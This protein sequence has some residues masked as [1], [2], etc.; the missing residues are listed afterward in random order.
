M[1]RKEIVIGLVGNPNCG[2]TTLFNA[3]TGARQ[4]VANWGGVT[5]ERREGYCSHR[6][7]RIRIIDLPGTYSLTSYT[8]EELITRDFILNDKPDFIINVIDSGNLE[9]NLYLTSQLV[10]MEASVILALNMFDEAKAR[11]LEINT[12][13]LGKLMGMPAIPTVGTRGEGIQEILDT[14]ID[15]YT[16]PDERLRHITIPFGRDIEQELEKIQNL[17]DQYSTGKLPYPSRWVAIRLMEGDS[18]VEKKAASLKLPEEFMDEVQNSRKHIENIYRDDIETIFSDVRYGFI[19]GA[20]REVVRKTLIRRRDLT[21]QIDRVITNKYLGFPILFLFMWILFHLTFSL[22]EYPMQLIESAVSWLG[23]KAQLV[24]PEGPLKQLV[25]EGVIGGVGGVIVFLPNILILF[26]GIS[27][28]EDTGYMAR[29]A[30]IMDKIMHRMGLHGKSFIPLV[31]GFG[32]NVPAIMATRTLE[33]KK[34]RIVT[35]LINPFMSCSARL[36][37]FVLFAGVFFHQ[38]AGMVIFSLYLVG[39]LLAFISARI[40]N[41]VFFRGESTPFVMELPPY[42][43]PT[44]K[45]TILHMWDRASH[46]LRKMGGVILAFSIIIWVLG[47]YPKSPEVTAH[48]QQLKS[49]TRQEYDTRIENLVRSNRYDEDTVNSLKED[50]EKELS[51]IAMK[52]QMAETRE[53]FIG[54]FGDIIHPLIKPLGF[55]WQMGISLSTGF[56]AKEVVVSTM[57]VLYQGEHQFDSSPHAAEPLEERLKDPRFH[58][59]PLVAYTFMLFVL[60]YIPCIATIVVIGREIGWGWAVFSI[61][62]QLLVAWSFSFLVYNAGLLLGFA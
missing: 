2:K 5:V 29:S 43:M 42:R 31:M 57:S 21:E 41:A 7:Y 24:M 37:V 15:E 9:R 52:Q 58:I 20:A 59:T 14:I 32:C 16:R 54:M 4:K 35:I 33:N 10:N 40:F 34:D 1:S 26:L 17:I 22:G 51:S 6:G 47:E 13:Q 11:G 49:E 62:Y 27:F 19:S 8:I 53:T 60:L 38:H 48:Y 12:E 50:M 46:Y 56:V 30:F 3:F 45:T 18:D 39:I 55:N 23:S 36:P 44:L 61:F 28:M 25:I